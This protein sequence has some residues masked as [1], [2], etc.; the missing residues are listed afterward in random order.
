MDTKYDLVFQQ[1]LNRRMFVRIEIDL[2]RAKRFRLP[3]D[4]LTIF[5]VYLLK[6]NKSIIYN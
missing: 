3:L 2:N 5:P 6:T 1:V 4:Y